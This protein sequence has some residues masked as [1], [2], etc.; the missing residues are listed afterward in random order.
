MAASLFNPTKRHEMFSFVHL[1]PSEW[2]LSFD[3]SKIPFS[4]ALLLT[5]ARG[6]TKGCQCS[7]R[8]APGAH[9]HLP[10]GK[11]E[12]ASICCRAFG[13]G[14]GE[15]TLTL[16]SCWQPGSDSFSFLPDENCLL[17][18]FLLLSWAWKLIG[19]FLYFLHNEKFPCECLFV[20]LQFQTNTNSSPAQLLTSSWRQSG[21][22][23]KERQRVWEAVNKTWLPLLTICRF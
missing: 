21:V 7:E 22:S 19:V 20:T 14:R 3:Y 12:V 16:T 11:L 10:L 6:V 1:P 13:V 17:F 23:A 2:F 15:R 5:P 8:P 4:P 9:L 18:F